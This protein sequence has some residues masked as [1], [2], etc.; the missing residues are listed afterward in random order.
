MC[1]IEGG[2]TVDIQDM[3]AQDVAQWMN[4]VKLNPYSEI[5]TRDINGAELAAWG[6]EEI[7][8]VFSR[9]AVHNTNLFFF[10]RAFVNQYQTSF[11]STA[12]HSQGNLRYELPL[13]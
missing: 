4:Q 11:F 5:T 13:T 10:F 9:S 3:T 12:T 1:C 8:D 2:S 7:K 6:D